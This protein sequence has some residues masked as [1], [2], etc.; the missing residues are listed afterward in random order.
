MTLD[1]GTRLFLE[2]EYTFKHALTYEVAYSGLLHERRRLWHA[3]IVEVVEGL[4]GDRLAEQ[5]ERLAYHALRGEVWDKALEY[6]RQA[7][8]KAMTR[9]AYHEAVAYFEQALRPLQHLPERQDTRAQ[10]ID[11]RLALRSALLPSNDSGRILAYLRE[12]E[13]L[14]MAPDDHRRLG[15]ISG[16]LS[17]HFRNTGA[18]DQAIASA[19]RALALATAGGDSAEA[20]LANLYLGAA[21]WTR[22][23]YRQSIDYLRQTT[24]SLQGIRRRDRLGIAAVPSVQAFA[25]LAVCFAEMGMFPDGRALG[26]EGLQIAEA[27]A[28]PS[29]LMW[30]S[31]GIGLLF[32]RQG[33]LSRALAW[34]ERAV[35]LCQ[36]ADLSAYA[37]RMAAALGA[38]Y[39]MAGR[40]AEAMSLLTRVLSQSVA[41]D[42]IGYQVL[43][44]LALGESERLAGCLEEA[45]THADRALALARKHH[46]R[47]HEAYSRHLLGDI[48]AHRD[49][50][51]T[52]AEAHYQ[53]ASHWPRHSVCDRSWRTA[54]SASAGW[55]SGLPRE[56]GLASS[57]APPPTSTAPWRCASGC[58]RQKPSGWKDRQANTSST[59]WG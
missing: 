44:C 26:E 46:E 31:H 22:G 16:Y 49:P 9:S 19:Q 17:V 39:T 30:A 6:C 50:R 27:I 59:Q 29:S 15:R 7:G 40:T 21:Y 24:A 3:R 38:A 2:H 13:T 10:A 53:Q 11:L 4:A 36:A 32:L 8:E 56:S 1:Y 48:A 35:G 37:P 51:S 58:H 14:A 23:E 18:Y 20:A 42:R 5:V 55:L 52:L 33:D 47:G 25:F 34:L 54:I 12:A 28:Q 45:H 57:L 43:C 41:G